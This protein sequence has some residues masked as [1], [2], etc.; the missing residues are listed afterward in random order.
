MNMKRIISLFVLSTVLLIPVF[1]QTLP[2]VAAVVNLIRSEPIPVAQLRTEVEALERA[3]GRSLT[4]GE[5]REVLDVM[6]NEKLVMQAAERDRITVSD[7]EV[8][9]QLQEFRNQVAQEI[10]RQPTDAEFAQVIRNSYNVEMPAFREQV[11]KQLIIN[12]YMMAKR[13]SD[14]QNIRAPT[15][16]EIVN[17]FSLT[18]TQ[19]VRPDT[20]RITMIQVP[21]TDT[22]SKT[23]AR[24]VADRLVREIGNNAGRFDEAMLRGQS[25]G[26]DYRAS[27]AGYIFRNL[28]TQQAA[29]AAF[30]T[31]AFSLRQGEVS[32]L[33]ETPSFFCI[34]KVTESYAQKN[35]ELDDIILGYGV[36][37]REYIRAGLT[38][39]IQQEVLT[40]VTEE[41][42]TELRRGNPF[43]IYENNLNW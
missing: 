29:G 27:D 28:E 41:L 13:Q 38:Q 21:F 7:N 17:H 20:V 24:T 31:A 6:I 32:G 39:Q 12:K 2:Q 36:T 15:D 22:A 4:A 3:N 43:T 11:R 35:L 18:R 9:Q 42:V 16:A 5:R 14:L 10:G 1:A 30:M 23:R 25:P 34:I 40:R 8:N 19:Y 33:L 37:V 26:A